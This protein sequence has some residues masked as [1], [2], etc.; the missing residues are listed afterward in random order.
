[1]TTINT[2]YR[3]VDRLVSFPFLS[4]F[5]LPFSCSFC[6]FCTLLLSTVT[7][8]ELNAHWKDNGMS[9]GLEWPLHLLLLW[10]HVGKLKQEDRE[11]EQSEQESREEGGVIKGGRMLK[12]CACVCLSSGSLHVTELKGSYHSEGILTEE[13]RRED[14]HLRSNPF[15]N[16][17]HDPT[18]TV[19]RLFQKCYRTGTFLQTFWRHPHYEL[20][21]YECQGHTSHWVII[22]NGLTDS[23][24]WLSPK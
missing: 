11:E 4:L 20:N 9:S 13:A 14:P 22:K 15:L 24:L 10:Q 12:V 16:A 8:S 3:L 7:P 19:E 18:L 6:F 17:A 5:F 21:S 1:M 23:S 2:F